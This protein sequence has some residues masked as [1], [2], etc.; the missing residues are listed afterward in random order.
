MNCKMEIN[1]HAVA[2]IPLSETTLEKLTDVE[3]FSTGTEE[4]QD[5]GYQLFKSKWVAIF[6][7]N[8]GGSR[9][10]YGLGDY[11][12]SSI[13]NIRIVSAVVMDRPVEFI[14]DTSASF[15]YIEALLE[16]LY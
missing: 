12:P 9:V 11:H 2:L 10:L 16:T 1:A 13:D 8:D 15:E 5:I 3:I 6:H 4:S 14:C 7:Y